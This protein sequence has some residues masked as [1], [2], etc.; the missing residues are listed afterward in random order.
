MTV[1][2]LAALRHDWSSLRRRLAQRPGDVL[3]PATT[4]ALVIGVGTGI[5]SVVNGALL[6]PLPFP[7]QARLV[8]VFTMSPG[9]TEIRSRNP[10]ASIDFVRFRERMQTLDRLEVIWQRERGLVGAGDPI[11]V[12]T[13]SVS[14]GFFE[15]LG[16]HARLG[17]TF[18]AA[19][20]DAGGALA[21]LGQGVWQRV[22]GGDKR[23]A[24]AR[25]P[26]EQLEEAR[27]HTA[28]L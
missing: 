23:A 7:D 10:L 27:R 28:G 9:T 12:K 11:I 15:L 8:R 25:V 21:A 16:G 13:G 14:S 2:R 1:F 19:G 24:G 22:L 6:R 3:I 5:F 17:R 26:A 4:L 18:T 20:E